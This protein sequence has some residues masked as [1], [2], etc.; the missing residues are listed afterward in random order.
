[1]ANYV[2]HLNNWFGKISVM[3]EEVRPTHISIYFTLFSIWN[4]NRFSKSIK[5]TR[6]DVMQISKVG[7]NATYSRCMKDM[8]EWG[9][10]EYKPSDRM[11]QMSEV[12]M[13]PMLPI[14]EVNNKAKRGKKTGGNDGTPSV[15]NNGDNSTASETNNGTTDGTTESTT[16]RTST[17]SKLNKFNKQYYKQG[18]QETEN[19]SN[20]LNTNYDEE[21]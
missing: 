18:K 8:V 2:S 4:I 12:I 21:I 11:Y 15:Q 19:N 9:W 16:G 13:L 3:E 10:I 5:I 17:E 1:M 14:D 20:N 7:G 6:N